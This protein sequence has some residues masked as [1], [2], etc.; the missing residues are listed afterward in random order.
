MHYWVISPNVK[1][2]SEEKAWIKAIQDTQRAYIGYGDDSQKGLTFS[3]INRGDLIIV[4]KR[5]NWKPDMVLCGIADNTAKPEFE[6]IM[7][8]PG[9][10]RSIKLIHCISKTD[11]LNLNLDF[12][13]TTC[14]GDNSQ[15]PA[16]YELHPDKNE[17]D[18]NI[19]QI[20]MKEIDKRR[21]Y[22]Y[23]NDITKIIKVKKNIIL[24][25]APG[26]GKTYQTAVL[27]LAIVE[28][29]Q[30]EKTDYL[31]PKAVMKAYQ[32]YCDKDQIKFITF[33]QS[34][35]YE[36]FVEGIRP[37]EKGGNISYQVKPG[38][39]KRL[40]DSARQKEGYD[41]VECIDKYLNSIVGYE[42]RKT[43][44]T[45]TGKSQLYVWWNK[46]NDTISTRSIFSES[47]KRPDY[48]PSPL[49][50]E[51]VK[52]QA[53]GDGEENNWVQYA[54]AFINAVRKEYSLDD[55]SSKKPYVLIIDEI[56][57]GNVSKIFGELITLL[58]ADKRS[59]G[60]HP[61]AVELPYSG[62]QF[63]VPSNLYIIGTMN[64]TDR[65][66]GTID[67][68][69]RRR[70]AFVT[71]VSDENVISC[72]Y[73]NDSELRAKALLLFNSVK[74]FLNN[75][76]PDMDMD[77]LMIGHSY[78]FAA[79]KDELLSKLQYE[80]IPLIKEYI[81][82]GIISIK[83]INILDKKISEWNGILQ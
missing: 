10:S 55:D 19:I 31:N 62:E 52:L 39:F 21:M 53:V 72:Y 29:K 80:I 67:Y 60:D 83:E 24:Q 44:P 51:K 46:G 45:I 36:D 20:L 81:R 12:N 70:F 47:N 71:L 41:I 17:N 18:R 66:T 4:G 23:I 65:S 54:Q 32:K 78:F 82:D 57:R 74:E 9:E 77:D 59:A 13:N 79:T 33:H 27:A 76:N 8:T 69:I 7:E 28:S 5:R 61:I 56:N 50:I 14:Y 1:N 35:D 15:I 37:I 40:C 16:I 25:G 64:T 38:I 58:E 22:N 48:S 42:N 2:N 75:S 68:A 73:V 30:K 49:N 3:K 63:R 11:L 6:K 34:M 43:I 26:T